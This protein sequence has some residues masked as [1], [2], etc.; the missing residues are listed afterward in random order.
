MP[1]RL[2]NIILIII[3][4]S[5]STS[6][7]AAGPDNPVRVGVHNTPPLIFTDSGGQVQGIFA[8]LLNHIAAEESWT[9]DYVPCSYA[10]C[11][12][13]LESGELDLLPA[14]SVL[15]DLEASIALSHEAILTN[16][17]Q[18]ISN[19]NDQIRHFADL[20]QLTVATVRGDH[21]NDAIHSMADEL[22]IAIRFVRLESALDVVSQVMAGNVD[23]GLVNQ[24]SMA[25]FAQT[26][27]LNSGSMLLFN[28]VDI[29]LA[30]P[31]GQYN[32]YLHTIDQH[33]NTM[34]ATEGSIYYATLNRWLQ[35]TQMHFPMWLIWLLT[36]GL[37]ILL[38]ISGGNV[39]LRRQISNST[40][41]LKQRT[42]ELESLLET[43]RDL[44]EI[45]DL[46]DLLDHIAQQ[47]IDLLDADEALLLQM[48]D[49][50]TLIPTLMKGNHT[51]ETLNMRIPVGT[52]L[53]GYCVA[54]NTPVIAN[55]AQEDERAYQAP[56]TLIASVEHVMV[57]PLVFRDRITGALWVNRIDKPGFTSGD[58]RMLTALALHCSTAIEN[59]RLYHE[60]ERHNNSLEELVTERTRALQ[61]AN[62]DLFRLSRLKDEFV[63]NVSHELRTPIASL[64]LRRYL[65]AKQ[66]GAME[67]HL[68]VVQREIQR[69]EE[70]VENLL[71][72]SRLDQGRIAID[73][74]EMDLNTL[75]TE[76]G[77]DRTLLANE[78]N[79]ELNIATVP[80]LPTAWA[81]RRLIGQ[82][83]SIL[84]TNALNYTPSGGTVTIHTLN[85]GTN[86]QTWTGF[87]VSDNGPGIP[88]EEQAQLFDRFYRGSTA[89]NSGR[90]GTGLGLAIAREIVERHNGQISVTSEGVPGKGCAFTVLLPNFPEQTA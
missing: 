84:L 55:N 75:V 20:D 43:T 76:M 79:L 67:T 52:G 31:E 70:I 24:A 72:L 1:A 25:Y 47:A 66:P 26:S 29:Q 81:D 88:H 58:L 61:E 51:E 46:D 32:T 44:A 45:R 56:G 12:T 77:G 39:L 4:I 89:R 74:E 13:R 83:L 22:D 49:E 57:T 71:Y 64:K 41:T 36:I 15:A 59:A 19:P 9:L 2:V 63:S 62:E 50:H 69:L 87:C 21:Y 53:T 48:E 38:L 28:P 68:G 14:A 3:L 6:T 17:G 40:A 86:G 35:H 60:L 73:L 27:G 8:E 37:L 16:W 7:V 34:K 85:N 5:L 42:R 65:L 78:R 30:A 18:I 82:V 23:A 10:A 11:L 90:A 80:A 33:L 54:H